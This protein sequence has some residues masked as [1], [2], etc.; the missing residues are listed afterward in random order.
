MPFTKRYEPISTSF[1]ELLRLTKS[2]TVPE[3]VNREILEISDSKDES[4]AHVGQKRIRDRTEKGRIVDNAAKKAK[5][6][7]AVKQT[8]LDAHLTTI[9]KVCQEEGLRLLSNRLMPYSHCTSDQPS[10]RQFN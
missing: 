7:A 1:K 9:D 8:Q 2:K 5:A 4:N 10:F 6:D 3:V